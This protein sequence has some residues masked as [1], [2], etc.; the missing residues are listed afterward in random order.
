MNILDA[1]KG[2][3]IGPQA[4]K[5]WLG[6]G[7]VVVPKEVAQYRADICIACPLNVQSGFINEQI[8]NAIRM[9]V[10]IKNQLNLRVDGEKRLGKCSACMCESKLKIWL[11]LKNI[12]PE[13][14]ERANFDPKC[15]LL[16]EQD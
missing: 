13:P 8:A 9:Q 2:L 11:P 5:D 7:C 4:I 16:N 12:L 15:W 1:I 6:E 14:S 10:G 3:N